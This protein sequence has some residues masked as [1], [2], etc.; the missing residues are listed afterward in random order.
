VEV[1]A[2]KKGEKSSKESEKKENKTSEKIVQLGVD[3]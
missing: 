2:R 3:S 1:V